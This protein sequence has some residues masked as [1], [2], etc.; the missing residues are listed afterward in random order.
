MAV[1]NEE[2]LDLLPAGCYEAVTHAAR[3][4][5]SEAQKVLPVSKAMLFGSY[6]KGNATETSDVDV[7]FFLD[8]YDGR[9]RIDVLIELRR[10]S[11][12]FDDSFDPK[13]F[14]AF[15]PIAFTTSALYNG[16]PF[17]KEVLRTGVDIL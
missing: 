3:R 9:R 16:N 15:E 2:E 4:F 17:V 7:C 10:L 6:A 5:A 8:S 1:D 11:H 13:A 14:T 12:K